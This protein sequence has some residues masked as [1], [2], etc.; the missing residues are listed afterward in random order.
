MTTI[1]THTDTP[2]V[3]KFQVGR[4]GLKSDPRGAHVRM[5]WQG[6]MLLGEVVETYLRE[7]P[8]G[9]MLKV[10]HFNGEPWPVDPGALAV[11]VLI[12]RED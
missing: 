7:V 2:N 6:R 4:W 8:S 10:K 11:D 3:T 5:E 12:R 1:T 9:I